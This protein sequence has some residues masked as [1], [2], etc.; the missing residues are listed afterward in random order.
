MDCKSLTKE[1][2]DTVSILIREAQLVIIDH[3]S[4]HHSCVQSSHPLLATED[5]Q[6]VISE[7]K[8]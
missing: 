2:C 5:V 6:M 3:N 1:G 4:S 8:F 7:T